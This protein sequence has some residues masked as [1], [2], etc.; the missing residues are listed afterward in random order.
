MIIVSRDVILVF[1]ALILYLNQTPQ[2]MIPTFLG[3]CTTAIQL[4]FILL[5]LGIPVLQMGALYFFPVLLIT[6]GLTVLSGLHY[7][8]RGIQHLDSEGLIRS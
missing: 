6:V 5:I 8:Y 7:I 4:F 3:K 2:E 1:G